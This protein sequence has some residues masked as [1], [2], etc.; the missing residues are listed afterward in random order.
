[1][2]KMKIIEIAVLAATAFLAAIKSLIK[3]FEYANDFW[4]KTAAA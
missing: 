4:C 1:M 3:F 2:K